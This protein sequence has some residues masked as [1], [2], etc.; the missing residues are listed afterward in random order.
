[1]RQ[2]VSQQ[3][4]VSSLFRRPVVSSAGR[5]FFSPVTVVVPPS[6]AAALILALLSV[7]CLGLAAW[8]VEIPRRATALGVLM[9]PQGL[10]ELVADT[11]GRVTGIHVAEGQTIEHGDRLVGLAAN[12]GQLATRRLGMLRAE[13]ALVL[14]AHARRQAIDRQRRASFAERR[15]ALDARL[16]T[17]KE[18]IRQQQEHCRLL[19]RRLR[20]RRE[21]AGN[22]SLSLDALEQE[23]SLVATARSR[24]ASA[25]RSL[26]A[27]TEERAELARL[28]QESDAASSHR[29]VL[30]DLEL[31]RLDRQ[32]VEREHEA[33]HTLIAQQAGIV[34]RI[35]VQPGATVK[36]GDVLLKLYRPYEALEAWLYLPSSSAASVKKGQAVKLRVDAFPQQLAGSAEAVVTSVA[37]VAVVPWELRIPLALDGPV[38]E[39]RAAL[40]PRAGQDADAEAR[41]L[42]GT[43]IRADIVQR[44]YRLYEY[45]LRSLGDSA[46]G[47]RA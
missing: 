1:M 27:I 36:A 40:R 31:K 19:E 32:L 45:L 6:G 26:L 35:N 20:R 37:R 33:G 4:G 25:N 23:Q 41:F 17:A 44:R 42:P 46:R 47:E 15:A 28:Q 34:A 43:A 12:G 3:T 18:E 38:F 7:A 8:I 11:P 16:A 30:H 39:I 21:L 13:R 22:G 5:R 14:E 9:P 10:V 29:E 24:L 2:E